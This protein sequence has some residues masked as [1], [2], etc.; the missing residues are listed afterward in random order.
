MTF[1]GS[2]RTIIKSRIRNHPDR[3]AIVGS[4]PQL[5]TGA[6]VADLSQYATLLGFDQP[7]EREATWYDQAKAN[8]MTSAQAMD[9]VNAR[10]ATEGLGGAAVLALATN[11]NNGAPTADVPE[12]Q[13]QGEDQG[14]GQG[15]GEGEDGDVEKTARAAVVKL[16]S[17]MGSGDFDGYKALLHRMAVKACTPPP[18]AIVRIVERAAIDPAK[19]KG[20]IPK[21]TEPRRL[22]ASGIETPMTAKQAAATFDVYDA[23]D[24]PATDA[25]YVWSE[26]TALVL[27]ELAACRNVFLTGQAGTGKTTFAK[28]VAARFNR[29]FVRISCTDQTDAPT[30]V[31]M[32]A[33]VD[34]STVWQDG[35][36]TAAIRRPGTV[37]LIDEPS[38]AR[39]GAMMVLQSVLDA[40][41]TL[42]IPDTG[43]IV[44]VAPGVVFLAAD[45][46][47]GTG[48]ENGA[49]EG[50][51]VMNRATLD[52]F[53]ITVPIDYLP[54]KAESKLLVQRT[55]IDAKHAR[56]LVDFAGKTR[57]ASGEG[58]LSHGLG[59]RRLEALAGCIA[60]GASGAEA[61][62]LAVLQTAPYDD[63]EPLRQLWTANIPQNA[64]N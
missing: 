32:P 33:L 16:Q 15:E 25:S 29:P 57:K 5:V 11:T 51:R 26:H 12:E 45:N 21:I 46:T 49:Y 63:R 60:S 17:L 38:A 54:A 37:I 64:F 4:D 50:T 7:T 34:G 41:R 42:Q 47:S 43:E 62:H 10:A 44:P 27:A 3:E 19:I 13:D 8:G 28:Q 6:S 53:S 56:I 23:P 35:Q 22:D 9:A 18:A 1:K 39:P 30:L 24:A 14:E 36:L 40:D 20:H 2:A 58:N 61:L 59:F 55:G 48:D 31:G 52:R